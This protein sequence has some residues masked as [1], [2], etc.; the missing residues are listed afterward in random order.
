M[1]VKICIHH[2]CDVMCSKKTYDGLVHCFSMYALLCVFGQRQIVLFCNPSRQVQDCCNRECVW[3][4]K[5]QSSFWTDKLLMPEPQLEKEKCLMSE[6]LLLLSA[7]LWHVYKNCN[8]KWLDMEAKHCLTLSKIVFSKC[9][10]TKSVGATN[11]LHNFWKTG[12]AECSQKW[13]K[14]IHIFKT[15]VSSACLAIFPQDIYSLLPHSSQTRHFTMIL[16]FSWEEALNVALFRSLFSTNLNWGH[17]VIVCIEL[18]TFT[19]EFKRR[20]S[21]THQN[22]IRFIFS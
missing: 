9:S 5:T 11:N 17:L 7:A 12:L 4:K 18:V 13:R 1:W 19:K 20:I 22:C 2:Y 6:S 3:K 14:K 21:H 15:Y 10:I 8:Q 16:V